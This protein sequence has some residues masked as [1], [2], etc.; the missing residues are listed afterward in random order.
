[1]VDS[2]FSVEK[3]SISK[4]YELLKK[5]ELLI[6][7]SY[8]RGKV[9]REKQRME[10]IQSILSKFPIGTLVMKSRSDAYD[11]VDGQQ[12]LYAISDYVD[13]GL[14]DSNGKYINE[15]EK[16]EN[17]EFM[18]Y[19]IPVIILE[20]SLSKDK[21]SLI[22]I[23]L[24]EGIPLSTA[25]KIYA[26]TGN[27]RNEFVNAFFDEGNKRFFGK[28]DDKRYRA[29]LIAAHLLTIELKSNYEKEVENEK[30]FPDI[31]YKS[32]VEINAEY[33]SKPLPN[34]VVSNYSFNLK[35]I[36][37]HLDEYME[38]IRVRE[39]TPLYHLIS[40]MRWNNSLSDTKGRRLKRF[41]QEFSDDLGKFSIYD[42]E[43]PKK[44]PE[45]I[46]R[47]LMQYKAYSRQGL[48]EE[49]LKERL[50]IIKEEFKRRTNYSP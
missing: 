32:L 44:M 7:Y 50:S 22:F 14:T 4:L 26:F 3:F 39:I 20:P 19:N 34:K 28:L 23:R 47:R 1:M 40:Y 5:K 6:D 38:K 25:E 24:Q 17:K 31:D 48:T 21:L 36:G 35:F 10:L 33:K 11:V 8:Q 42:E 15:L 43:P 2:W 13:G 29:R 45:K 46:F 18:S 16:F 9:W 41:I 37:K 12:R 49:S 30:E 27:F